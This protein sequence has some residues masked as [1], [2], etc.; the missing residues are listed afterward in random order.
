M[1]T[2]GQINGLETGPWWWT[3]RHLTVLDA[4]PFPVVIS[5]VYAFPLEF[6]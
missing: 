2:R 3:E 5:V 1:P 6:S 4:T